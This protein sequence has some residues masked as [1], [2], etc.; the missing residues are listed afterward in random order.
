IAVVSL[1]STTATTWVVEVADVLDDGSFAIVHGEQL[2][3]RL[4]R[5][6]VRGLAPGAEQRIDQIAETLQKGIARFHDQGNEAAIE[7]LATPFERALEHPEAFAHRP[8]FARRL[9]RAGMILVRAYRNVGETEGAR[10]IARDLYR[11]LPGLEPSLAEA[12]LEDIH[13]YYRERAAVAATGAKLTLRIA[14]EPDCRPYLNGTPIA[15]GVGKVDSDRTHFATVRCGTAW[16]P[17]WRVELRPGEYATVPISQYPPREFELGSSA[18]R[19]RR[20]A[21]QYL[22]VITHWGGVSATIGI[23]RPSGADGGAYTVMRVPEDGDPTWSRVADRERIASVLRHLMPSVPVT[24]PPPSAAGP[25]DGNRWLDWTL[26]AT[27]SA[28]ITA[29]ATLAAL[30]E[31]HASQLPCNFGGDSPVNRPIGLSSRPC[32]SSRRRRLTSARVGY[33]AALVASAGLT[34]WGLLRHLARDR[35]EAAE[36]TAQGA[37]I[38]IQP[39]GR[40]ARVTLDI[41]W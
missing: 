21:T 20:R 19:S 30:T 1:G 38:R 37:Q 11:Y 17:I 31:S 34:T 29:G 10:G 24:S 41:S 18:D 12:R 25:P 36:H 3:G 26:V 8:A 23:G 33:T 14:G 28:G 32:N 27:G 6:R 7:E 5:S 40:R 22:R 4:N 16:G 15:G 39:I 9:F 13:F 2:R 35:A